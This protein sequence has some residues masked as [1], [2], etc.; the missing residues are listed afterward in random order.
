MD[1]ISQNKKEI[2][3]NNKILSAL[4]IFILAAVLVYVGYI[5]YLKYDSVSN[6]TYGENY[7]IGAT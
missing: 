5:I 3:A 4:A 2:K 1:S 7:T 6:T